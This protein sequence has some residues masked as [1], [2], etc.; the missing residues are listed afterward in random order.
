MERP[1]HGR[2]VGKSNN[3]RL[4]NQL[5]AID[6]YEK[7]DATVLRRTNSVTHENRAGRIKV[8][9][10]SIWIRRCPTGLLLADE[11]A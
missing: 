6:R 7:L 4:K 8:N 1:K 10:L 5:P 11:S 2:Q 3:S 9:F